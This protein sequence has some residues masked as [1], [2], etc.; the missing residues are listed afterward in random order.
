MLPRPIRG[1]SP[2]FDSIIITQDKWTFQV[3]YCG[4]FADIYRKFFGQRQD[5]FLAAAS[6]AKQYSSVRAFK[7]SSLIRRTVRAAIPSF[8]AHS[9]CE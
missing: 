4:Q 2:S 5:S 3:P 1:A 9:S 6:S 8:A 7:A